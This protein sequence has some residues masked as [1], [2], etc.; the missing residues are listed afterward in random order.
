MRWDVEQG[1]RQAAGLLERTR[2]LVSP[3]LRTAVDQL[4]AAMRHVSGYHFGWWD[5]E[6]TPRAGDGGKAVRP[7]LLMASSR[8]LGGDEQA[9]LAGAA[10]VELVHNFTL[11]HDDVMDRD[12]Q[13]R[14]RPTAWSVFGVA[15]AILAG[16][17]LQALAV[18]V[19]AADSHSAAP[20][21]MRLLA[22]CMIELC[23]GQSAD[24]A[25]EQCADVTSAQCL[26]MAEGKTGA[27]LGV[28]CAIGAQY[29]SADPATVRALDAFGRHLGLAFQLT[30][31]LLGI[32][33]DPEMTGKPVGA[34][35][36]ARKKSLPV[37]AALT[38][39]TEAGDELAALYASVGERHDPGEISRLAILV[40][41]AGGRS[42]AQ[43]QAAAHTARAIDQLETALPAPGQ[44]CE[45]LALAGLLIRRDG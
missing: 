8:A 40:E 12:T 29:A 22:D 38:S 11:L 43:E 20:S 23:E 1:G 41:R 6:G 39:L 33:G 28:A 9:V 30:D 31:D 16:D 27:L 26:D 10:A 3:V 45:L 34:D 18:K 24:C 14:H 37:V 21:A 44:A 7:A 36:A 35:L 17:V 19:L 5:P 42:W 4:P 32:W 2:E 13:R 25:F 15:D